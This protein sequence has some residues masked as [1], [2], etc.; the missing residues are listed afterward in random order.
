MTSTIQN[1]REDVN[2]DATK[3]KDSETTSL[4]STITIVEKSSTVS[5]F[6]EDEASDSSSLKTVDEI[7]TE[8]SSLAIKATDVSSGMII[9]LL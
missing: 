6:Q 5:Q 3:P 1:N 7:E 8:G 4:Q 2:T 9:A